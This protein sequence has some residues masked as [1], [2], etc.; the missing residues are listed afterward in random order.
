MR[1]DR[2]LRVVLLAAC[3]LGAGSTLAQSLPEALR[4]TAMVLPAAHRSRLYQRAAALDAMGA[5]GRVQLQQRLDEWNALPEAQRRER[6]ERWQAWQ[7]LP[8]DERAR[9]RAAAG[10]FAALPVQDQVDLRARF[11]QLDESRRHG[12]LL[13][14]QLGA[15]WER[16]QPLLM[17]VPAGQREPLLAAL[18][19][20]SAQQR[21]DLGVLAQRIPPQDRDRLRRELLAQR[22][23]DRGRWLVEQLD[24]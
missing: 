2:R 8:A 6:R 9:L 10:A 18:R 22:P 15:D 21:A 1:P 5:A 19:G 16:L 13:G 23:A 4:E 24:R 20:M 3:A 11:A 7:A 14:P 12:W 17:Q